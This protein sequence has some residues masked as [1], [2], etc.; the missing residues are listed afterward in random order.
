MTIVLLQQRG[1]ERPEVVARRACFEPSV[2]LLPMNESF[3]HGV[4]PLGHWAEGPDAAPDYVELLRGAIR[5]PIVEISDSDT[6][7]LHIIRRSTYGG[8]PIMP[9]AAPFS[10]RCYF[11]WLFAGSSG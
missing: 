11:L 9:S 6:G 10:S 3:Q 1:G 7:Q 8:E 5:E 4:L 2:I